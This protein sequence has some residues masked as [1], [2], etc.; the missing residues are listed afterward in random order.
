MPS[1]N[2]KLAEPVNVGESAISDALTRPASETA[3]GRK[4]EPTSE[5]SVEKPARQRGNGRGGRKAGGAQGHL[6]LMATRGVPFRDTSRRRKSARLV[7]QTPHGVKSDPKAVKGILLEPGTRAAAS[8]GKAKAIGERDGTVRSPHSSPRAGKP[9]TRRRGT[10]DTECRQ[11]GD[12]KPS[13]SVNT[14]VILDMQRKLYR[15]SRSDRD[16]VFTDLF[17]L[18]CDCRTLELAWKCLSQNQ[19][20]R[21]PGIDGVTRRK[22]EE[23]QGGAIDFLERL[24]DDLRSGRYI[25]QPVRQKLIPKPG[26][27]G[28]FRPL[29]IPTLRDRLVQMALKIILEPIFE[30]DF[31]PNSYGFRRGRSTLDALVRIQ[32]HMVPSQK[33][34]CHVTAVIEGDIKACFDNVDHHHLMERVR[35]RIGDPKVLRL[36]RAFLQAGIMAESQVRHPVAG[37][38]QGG[39][40]SPLLANIYLT[41]IDE[42]YGRWTGR[43]GEPMTRARDARGNDRRN[44]KPTF[45][46]VRYA[47]DFVIL[48]NGTFEDAEREREALA[49]VLR[50]EL[51]MELSMEKTLIT[52]PRKGFQ[53][54]GYRVAVEP[55]KR[56]RLPVGKLR[57]PKPKLQMLRDRL[58]SMTTTSTI[59]QDLGALLKKL[60]PIIT[61]WRNYYRYATGATKDFARLDWWLWHRLRRWFVKKHPKATAHEIRRRYAR[62]DSPTSWTW[63]SDQGTLRRFRDGG[64]ARHVCRNKISNGWNNELD[65]TSF[66]PKVARPIAGFTWLGEKLR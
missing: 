66:Y 1:R 14:G 36:I 22:I 33:G 53:F 38:P 24:R 64:Q 44:G 65:G 46:A 62:R 52:D 56:S 23:R 41:A 48:V 42:R 54:L 5:A 37:T 25:P 28:Q 8:L 57:I 43:P 2:H 34:R 35:N 39:I 59:G 3:M 50:K 31:F 4:S 49:S 17:N 51:H 9:P 58:R 13:V 11:E 45:Y 55:S 20:S 7:G 61:G 18:V 21:T 47:D 6:V 40:I 60:N 10:V 27:P 15:W 32:K 29:G 30:A 26:K 19:G 12:G 63:G 16:K